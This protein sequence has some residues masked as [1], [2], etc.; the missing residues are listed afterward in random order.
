MRAKAVAYRKDRRAYR[1]GQAKR[2]RSRRQWYRSTFRL[3]L[4]QRGYN[5]AIRATGFQIKRM[6][7]RVSQWVRARQIANTAR[8]AQM[9]KSLNFRVTRAKL[10]HAKRSAALRRWYRKKM[11]GHWRAG[12]T[13]SVIKVVYQYQSTSR[14][15][16]SRFKTRLSR[17]IFNGRESIRRF[18][19]AS[20]RAVAAHQ[21]RVASIVASRQRLIKRLQQRRSAVIRQLAAVASKKVAFVQREE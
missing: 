19:A 13:N 17:T 12:R 15:N 9:G 7:A 11:L 8:A 16:N 5:R 18:K 4:R 2:L 3:M 21:S 6:Q 14:I 20:A 1:A 10:S